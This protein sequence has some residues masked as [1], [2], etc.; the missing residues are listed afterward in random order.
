LSKDETLT[1]SGKRK[2]KL[3]SASKKDAQNQPAA[4][5]IIT[6]ARRVNSDAANEDRQC[7]ASRWLD[8]GG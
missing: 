6:T 3:D 8:A 4:S 5:C 2:Q 1:T 7:K